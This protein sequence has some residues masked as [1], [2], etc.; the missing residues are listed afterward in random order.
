MKRIFV[1]LAVMTAFTA[2]T[3]SPASAQ[4]RV[5]VNIDIQPAWGPVGYD[6]AE[7]YYL[8]DI[9]IYYYIPTQMYIYFDMGRW[10][11]TRYLPARYGYY[12]FYRGYKVVLNQRDPGATTTATAGN[13][14]TIGT[15]TPR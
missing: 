6:Y 11:H 1:I 13:M 5:S 10:I 14:P 4:V 7:Y 8:P 12:D 9:D 15:T 2:M 3:P